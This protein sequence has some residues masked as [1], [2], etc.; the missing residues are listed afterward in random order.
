[1]LGLA[2][3]SAAAFG[4]AY[5]TLTGFY[6]VQG[7]RIMIQRPATGPV[8]PLLATTIG[9]AAGSPLSG[10]MIDAIGYTTAFA[11]FAI[12]GLVVAVALQNLAEG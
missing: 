8:M 3:V 6:L 12:F 4:A 2:L 7:V 1:V 11:G 5:M 10:W 9:Q